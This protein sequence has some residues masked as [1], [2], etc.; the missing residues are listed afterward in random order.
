MKAFYRRKINNKMYKIGMTEGEKRH[1]I[2]MVMSFEAYYPNTP[3]SSKQLN[4]LLIDALVVPATYLGTHFPANHA[5]L[6]LRRTWEEQKH[7]LEYNAISIPVHVLLQNIE[8]KKGLK[9]KLFILRLGGAGSRLAP[10]TDEKWVMD[11]IHERIPKDV[12]LV[13]I[14]D[15]DDYKTGSFTYYLDQLLKGLSQDDFEVLCIRTQLGENKGNQSDL[16]HSNSLNM[17]SDG[18]CWNEVMEGYATSFNLIF[19]NKVMYDDNGL[20]LSGAMNA[21]SSDISI[22]VGGGNEVEREIKFVQD[23]Y[24]KMTIDDMNAKR[25]R[26]T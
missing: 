8:K 22:Y 17:K 21:I 1:L 24:L 6:K 11:V 14:F 9:R 23:Y 19:S 20:K 26:L 7:L 5:E 3:E 4:D 12:F 16:F 13:V 25:A 10:E 18:P 2:P 15:G